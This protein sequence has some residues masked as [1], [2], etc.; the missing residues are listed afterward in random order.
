MKNV[1]A[2]II[3]KRIN[4]CYYVNILMV[5]RHFNKYFAL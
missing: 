3:G 4:I 1:S 5:V 2:G